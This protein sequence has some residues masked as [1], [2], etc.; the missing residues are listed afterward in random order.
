MEVTSI[1]V[2]KVCRCCLASPSDL[3][4]IFESFYENDFEKILTNVGRYEDLK[5]DDLS[6]SIC[7]NCKLAAVNAFKFQQMCMESERSLRILIGNYGEQNHESQ[8][9]MIEKQEPNDDIGTEVILED[10]KSID[11]DEE[12]DDDDSEMEDDGS[13]EGDPTTAAELFECTLCAKS[14]YFTSESSLESH[15]KRFHQPHSQD[16]MIVEESSGDELGDEEE[17]EDS[18][19][20]NEYACVQ[21]DKVF[22]KAS[23]LV[24]TFSSVFSNA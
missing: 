8:I 9:L 12:D 6:V 23:Q 22:R 14:K 18:E 16:G 20:K 15:V 7:Q 5:A 1:D 4:P 24:C 17:E 13:D 3:E 11:G 19:S 2:K 10:L 21:C